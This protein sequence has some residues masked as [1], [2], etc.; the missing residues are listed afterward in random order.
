MDEQPRQ[1][2]PTRAAS[3]LNVLDREFLSS[4]DA[5]RYAH[6]RVGRRRERGYYGYILQRN[7]HRFV[8]T[9]PAERPVPVGP[10]HQ[11]IP[12][13]HALHGRFYSHPALSTL[14][15]TK[16]AQMR[17]STDEAA[18]HLLM[19][20]VDELRD[21]FG[22]R[23]PAYLSGAE[24]SLI[25]FT[26]DWSRGAI[27][28]PLLGS[29]LEPGP[30]A[31][32]L[33]AGAAKPEQL[34]VEAADAGDLR[35]LISNGRWRP[36]G[37][38][39]GPVV[40]GPWD[41]RVPERASFGAVFQSADEAA[42]DR[43]SK[44]MGQHEEEQT[45]FGF[46]LKHQGKERYIASELVPVSGVRDK[47]YSLGS[48]FGISRTGETLYPESFIPHAYFYSRQRVRHE[49]DTARKWLAQHFIVPKDLWVVAYNSRRRT[50]ME[51]RTTIPL[52]VSTQ[53]GALLK[54]NAR[55]GSK[56]FD[57][58]VPNMGLEVIQNNLASGKLTANDFVRVVANSGVLRVMRTSLCWDR[59]GP[60]DAY[61]TPS[62][63]LQRRTLGPVFLTADD[64]AVH[65][66]SRVPT[67]NNVGAF[68]GFILK[69]DDGLFV[70]TDPVRILQEDF[71]VNWIFPDEAV[72]FGLFPAACT[73]VARYRSR[74]PRA[75][76]VVLS[77]VDK[78]LYL[79]ML[80]VDVVYAAFMRNTQAF[81]EYLF[82]PDGSTIRYRVGN[83]ERI[84][85]DLG[86]ALGASGKPARDLDATW[87]KK[88][89][90][91]GALKPTEW[92]KK[93]VNTGYLHVV[94]GSRLWG[95]AREVTELQPFPAATHT[96][97]YPRAMTE[98][99]YS[100]VCVREQDCARLVH[101]QAGSRS[102]PGFG[103]ILRNARTGSFIATLPVE[104]LGSRLAYDRI[105]PGVLPYRYVDSGIV[106]CA[107]GAPKGL[108]DDDYRHFFSP[109]DVNLARVSVRTNQGYRPIYFSCA[110]GALLR[111]QPSAF[112]P[113]APLDRFG[114]IQLRDNPFAT[115]EQAQR[116][117]HAISRGTFSLTGY[118]RR[119]ALHGH[120]EVLVSSTYW[121]RQGEVGHDWR[122]YMP[123]VS[124][125]KLWA[126][127]SALPLG[128][129]FHHPDDAARHAQLRAARFDEQTTLRASAVLRKTGSYSYV[130]LEPL[131]DPGY[132]DEAIKRIFRTAS[133]TST[134]ASN[135]APQFPDGFELVASHQIQPANR[136][137][138][139]ASETDDAR[140]AA[141]ALVHA[142]TYALQAK[143][144]DISAYFYSTG[145][146]ALLK[147]VPVYSKAEESL[148]LAQ[149]TL[150][151]EEFI[152]RLADI[153]QLRVLDAAYGW[154]QTGRLGRDWKVRRK[155]V[156]DVSDKPTRDEL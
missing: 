55:K 131:V 49:R 144:F 66:R 27:L 119:M 149:Q 25:S 127:K 134:S 97:G 109:L 11:V 26:P 89:I 18:T 35:V 126:G 63:N 138:T 111:F 108:S 87:I 132:P 8:I 102:T 71:D 9:E 84:R 107:A 88:Q 80:S 141:P 72:T 34:V 13:N 15:A 92:V 142:H 101:E 147:Y 42:L 85:A 75:L 7:D 3:A 140:F 51:P 103:F 21:S 122:P 22:S 23:L 115:L 120:L 39:T 117:W 86:I 90:H 91:Q 135:R 48:L 139:T 94:V 154:N 65:A 64:A 153:G 32:G 19:F 82:A 33:A 93:L 99:A 20:S 47:L 73:L 68:G 1:P 155:E 17:W 128:P 112:D 129:V 113:A 67:G 96:T 77:R 78:A 38:I 29:E 143:G 41:R 70:A 110:D 104:V 16:V 145:H 146:G 133:D 37:K 98:P 136:T 36:R 43:Y 57:N 106:L 81:D 150:S 46:I 24:D 52:Y 2:A 95:P 105:F 118:I 114:Q 50:V 123:A 59:K 74:V 152:S 58:D 69:R 130:G 116:D 61:W 62:Q 83:W 125:D 44:D 76:P 53:D 137:V 14:D 121:S 151:S 4:D 28:L 124:A 30:F 79:N 54:Y 60:V 56:L 6:E 40:P 156:A 31:L 10:H 5:A 12:D 45:W 100:P 148:L